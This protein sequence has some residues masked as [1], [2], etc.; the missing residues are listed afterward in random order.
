MSHGAIALVGEIA[1]SPRP[2]TCGC[3]GGSSGTGSGAGTG[4]RAGNFVCPNAE[5]SSSTCFA[6]AV[7]LGPFLSCFG[8]L[9]CRLPEPRLRVSSSPEPACPSAP[10]IARRTL[11][12]LRPKDPSTSSWEYPTTEGSLPAPNVDDNGSTGVSGVVVAADGNVSE[13][14]PEI[15][16]MRYSPGDAAF[17]GC[18]LGEELTSLAAGEFAALQLSWSFPRFGDLRSECSR[19]ALSEVF[20]RPTRLG[21]RALRSKIVL[22]TVLLQVL[23]LI[24]AA[25]EEETESPVA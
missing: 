20:W 1:A 18:R 14:E 17:N 13:G 9:P 12:G 22:L 4:A 15:N 25:T 24:C 3:W 8:T 23:V 5:T 2:N 6:F 11:S 7:D 16:D 19:L 21:F 10:P